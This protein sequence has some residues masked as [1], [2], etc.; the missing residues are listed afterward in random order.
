MIFQ[1]IVGILIDTNWATVLFLY[2]YEAEF[3][4]SMLSAGKSVQL[5]V[6]VNR[7]PDLNIVSIRCMALSLISTRRQRATLLFPFGICSYWLRWTISCGLPFSDK[8]DD[9]KV[10]SNTDH[11]TPIPFGHFAIVLTSWYRQLPDLCREDL[12]M[13]L[14]SHEI[15][16]VFPRNWA[17]DLQNVQF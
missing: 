7:A 1:Q 2:S 6:K 5:H 12:R 14:W 17:N 16:E 13:L 11:M 8:R 15:H 4:Q 9:C 10:L 3:I